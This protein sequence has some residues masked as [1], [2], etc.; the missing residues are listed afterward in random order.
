MR[1]RIPE[2]RLTS[3]AVS[4]RPLERN[5]VGWWLRFYYLLSARNLHNS[6]SISNSNTLNV[7]TKAADRRKNK[8]GPIDTLMDYIRILIQ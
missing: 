1:I 4:I 7:Q 8:N 5:A 2:F 3:F 6:R